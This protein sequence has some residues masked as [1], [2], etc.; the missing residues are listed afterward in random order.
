MALN[1]T[2]FARQSSAKIT[3]SAIQQQHEHGVMTSPPVTIFIPFKS[4]IY[5]F[6]VH[7]Q[8]ALYLSR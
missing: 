2:S 7:L 6:T 3:A 5:S 8:Y 1:Y 4:E